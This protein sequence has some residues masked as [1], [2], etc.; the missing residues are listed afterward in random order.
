MGTLQMVFTI[1][2]FVIALALTVVVLAQDS[3]SGGMGAMMGGSETFF[4]KNKGKTKEALLKKL[5]IIFGVLFGALTLI[6]YI[7]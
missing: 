5:T 4:G 7:L 1:I 2:Q 6:I 3:K